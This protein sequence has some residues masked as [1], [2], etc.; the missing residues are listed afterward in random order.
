MKDCYTWTQVLCQLAFIYDVVFRFSNGKRDL[1]TLLAKTAAELGIRLKLIR[2]YTPHNNGKV[3]RS[4]R[5]E[6][7]CFYSYHAF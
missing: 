6:Q 7:K 1:P 2:P 4:R 5:E 3:E